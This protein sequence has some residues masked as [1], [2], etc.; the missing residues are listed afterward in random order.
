[1]PDCSKQ[2]KA[3]QDIKRAYP[4]QAL[5]GGSTPA[6][7]P[8]RTFHVSTPRVTPRIAGG[9][10][11]CCMGVPLQ[12]GIIALPGEILADPRRS[13]A[14][15]RIA[16]LHVQ[17][18]TKVDLFPSSS[19]RARARSNAPHASGGP[20]PSNKFRPAKGSLQR[21]LLAL[22]L[23]ALDEAVNVQPLASTGH[24]LGKA[25]FGRC[26]AAFG[27]RTQRVEITYHS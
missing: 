8:T 23:R 4:L 21:E 11:N 15:H 3:V 10:K 19:Q 25:C 1:M 17:Q 20:S 7:A 26:R 22:T 13:E 14:R 24:Y 27:C 16:L 12:S 9:M 6:V 5:R 2:A 18:R